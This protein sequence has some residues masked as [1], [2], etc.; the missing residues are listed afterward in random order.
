ML[1]NNRIVRIMGLC[2]FFPVLLFFLYDF[3]GA[4]FLSFVLNYK[5]SSFRKVKC[6]QATIQCAF[7]VFD[8]VSPVLMCFLDPI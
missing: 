8:H 3:F 6:K 2:H 4:I 1:V 7:I 5:H